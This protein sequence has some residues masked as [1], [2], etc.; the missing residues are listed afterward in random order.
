MIFMLEISSVAHR[1]VL[2]LHICY[3]WLMQKDLAYVQLMLS[4]DASWMFFLPRKISLK[5][6]CNVNTGVIVSM[7]LT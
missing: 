1:V 4:A 7:F 5:R 6:W 3:D 2:M